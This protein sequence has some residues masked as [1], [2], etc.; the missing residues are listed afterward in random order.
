MTNIQSRDAWLVEGMHL[1]L[2]RRG[3]QTKAHCLYTTLRSWIQNTELRA[4]TRLPSS[5]V[6][7][8][9]LGI[10]RNTALAAMDHLAAEGFVEA[11]AGAGM[12]V[13]A[14]DFS[15]S[16]QK[17]AAVREAGSARLSSRGQAL[18]SFSAELD[19]KSRAFAPGVPAFGMF[20]HRQWQRLL[21][22]HRLKARTEWLDYQVGGGHP[23]LKAAIADYVRLSRGVQCKSH[24]IV[25]TRGA[26]QAFDLIARLLADP[27]DTAWIEEPGYQGAQAAFVSA[28]QHVV[29]VPVDHTGIDTTHIPRESTAPRLIYVTP[30][31]QYPLGV[32]MPMARRLALI[33][34]AQRHKAW[35]IEDDYDSEFRYVSPPLSSLQGLAGA[36]PILYVGTFSKVLYPGLQ[37]GYLVA[38]EALVD[39]FRHANARLFREGDYVVQS[40]LAEFMDTGEFARHVARMRRCYRQRQAALRRVLA[41]A[42]ANGLSLSEG[43]AGMHLVAKFES[44]DFEQSLVDKALRAG[45]TLAPLSQY[46]IGDNPEPGLVLGYAAYD[47]Q[48]IAR[49]GQW[50][51]REWLGVFPNPAPRIRRA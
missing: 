49:S 44:L 50:L 15:T 10:S 42:V 19:I 9:A 31:H 23:A 11:H 39:D 26:Q 28:G 48:A 14:L 5:R 35:I 8:H 25:I 4:G 20:P 45:V 22:R 18:L 13:A 21:R 40:A 29:P 33:E 32:T 47:S 6:L 36:P 7:A 38:P 16:R 1:A 37:L 12:Y 43:H 24:Q 46:F 17:E 3:A 2:D 34:A 51:S 30:S 41:P 27:G